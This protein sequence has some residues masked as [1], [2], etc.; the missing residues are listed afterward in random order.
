MNVKTLS[1]KSK[2][3]NQH[4][5]S[6]RTSDTPDEGVMDWE[7]AEVWI[8]IALGVQAHSQ[9]WETTHTHQTRTH[10]NTDKH[11]ALAVGCAGI[12]SSFGLC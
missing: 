2:H 12:R 8:P 9:P 10:T 3:T 5:Y 11:S 6:N 1:V 4:H 7:P